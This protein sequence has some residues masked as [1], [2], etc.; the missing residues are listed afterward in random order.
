MS[1]HAGLNVR[2][3][4]IF[5]IGEHSIEVGASTWREMPAL[6][7]KDDEVDELYRADSGVNVPSTIRKVPET[8]TVRLV[9]PDGAVGEPTMDQELGYVGKG[10]GRMVDAKCLRT[11][12][13]QL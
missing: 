3:Q 12:R 13:G 6:P 5:H 2:Y 7:T 10:K 1:Q 9:K 11:R 8:P 4:G